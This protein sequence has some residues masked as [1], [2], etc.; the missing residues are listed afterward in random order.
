MSLKI[1]KIVGPVKFEI[2]CIDNF[3][4]KSLDYIK[5]QT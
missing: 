4:S 3:G 5:I 1:I 2:P